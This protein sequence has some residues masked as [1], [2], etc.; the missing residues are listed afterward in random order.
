MEKPYSFY[1]ADALTNSHEVCS[2][3]PAKQTGDKLDEL[4]SAHAAPCLNF[5]RKVEEQQVDEIQQDV[6]NPQKLSKSRP[7]DPKKKCAKC[8]NSPAYT[9]AA[10]AAAAGLNP[11][12]DGWERWRQGTKRK[13]ATRRRTATAADA[14][15][16]PGSVRSRTACRH[17]LE[18][19]ELGDLEALKTR[20][21]YA[22]DGINAHR[23]SD[24][25]KTTRNPPRLPPRRPWQ[26][27]KRFR[28]QRTRFSGN[29]ARKLGI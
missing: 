24:P 1:P 3:K 28:R 22:S 4:D 15:K 23:G 12:P 10:A 25:P 14:A 17:R 13:T 19:R 9:P 6:C 20:R 27:R 7:R 8:H 18:R 11:T 21:S 26:R 16:A 29:S 2:G 5:P